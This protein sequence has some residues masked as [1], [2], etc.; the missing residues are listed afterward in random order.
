MVTKRRK[1]TKPINVEE[2][3]GKIEAIT[4][5][6]DLTW[7]LLSKATG[8]A[9]RSLRRIDRIYEA[10]WVRKDAL[11]ARGSAISRRSRIEV[12][13][14]KNAYLRRILAAKDEIIRDKDE[15]INLLR[16]AFVQLI[17][18]GQR[19]GIDVERL[20]TVATEKVLNDRQGK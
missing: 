15:A 19:E 17:V 6:D 14:D 5:R 11:A 2:V 16:Q 12:E 9:E 13:N 1:S 3:I 8:R 7:D 4:N 18:N 20:W 10:F